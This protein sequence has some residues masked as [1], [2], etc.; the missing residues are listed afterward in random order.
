[1]QQD[2]NPSPY[3]G[4]VWY[5]LLNNPREWFVLGLKIMKGILMGNFSYAG[6]RAVEDMY[7]LIIKIQL[8][9]GVTNVETR[10]YGNGH[11]LLS[12]SVSES[13]PL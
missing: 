3:S 11:I 10:N 5:S 1:M 7:N 12:P 2:P 13:N 6:E 9:L 8:L 4:Y